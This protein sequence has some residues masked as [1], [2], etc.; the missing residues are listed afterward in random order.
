MI[1][2]GIIHLSCVE[3]NSVSSAVSFGPL[4]FDQN[5][6][7]FRPWLFCAW[8]KAEHFRPY[9]V[10]WGMPRISRVFLPA[11]VERGDTFEPSSRVQCCD[12]QVE[13]VKFGRVS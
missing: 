5:L 8:L 6:G 11:A 1:L 3:G 4:A 13:R 9:S 2:K 12:G 7:Y 10:D